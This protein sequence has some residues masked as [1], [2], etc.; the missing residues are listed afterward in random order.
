MIENPDDTAN[1]IRISQSLAKRSLRRAYGRWHLASTP[2]P[3]YEHDTSWA[4]R[5]LSV[6]WICSAVR[7]CLYQSVRLS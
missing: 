7:R 1:T 6:C 4:P 5:R 2:L 3:A